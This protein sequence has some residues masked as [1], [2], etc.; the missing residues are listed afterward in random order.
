MLYQKIEQKFADQGWFEENYVQLF[1]QSSIRET[2]LNAYGGLLFIGIFLGILFTVATILIIY[3]KQISEGYEDHDRYVIMQKVGMSREEVKASIRSQILTV[4]FL[5]LVT[6]TIHVL[7]AYPVIERLLRMV[8]L[9]NR[10]LFIGCIFGC[11]LVF[12]ILYACVY[13]I[14]SR[15]Y[16]KLVQWS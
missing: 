3:Y 5:P 6:A 2:L 4:F 11:V 10:M 15:V 14:T 9:D 8:Q 16:Y 12:G 13:A 7:F 1:E